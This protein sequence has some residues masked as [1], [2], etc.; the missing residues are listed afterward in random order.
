MN[1]VDT[2]RLKQALQFILPSAIAL[3]GRNFQLEVMHRSSLASGC[4]EVS[5]IAYAQN[6]TT[7]LT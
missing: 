1:V 6:V 4:P 7:L 2:A 3:G 5:R